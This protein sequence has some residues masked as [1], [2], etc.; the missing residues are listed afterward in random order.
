MTVHKKYRD[1]ITFQL[2]HLASALFVVV[3]E[4]VDYNVSTV[5]SDYR[6]PSNFVDGHKSTG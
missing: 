6:L 5:W 4:P 1:K 3:A 2:F